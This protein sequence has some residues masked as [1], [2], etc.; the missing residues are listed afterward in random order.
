MVP[1]VVGVQVKIVG[2]PAFRLYPVVGTLNALA[3]LVPLLWGAGVARL[4]TAREER[5]MVAKKRILAVFVVEIRTF[6]ARRFSEYGRF[7][8]VKIL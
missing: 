3:E 1:E 7:V 6:S 2:E 4:R 5:T 8:I